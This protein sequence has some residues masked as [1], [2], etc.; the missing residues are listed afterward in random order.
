MVIRS[1]NFDF[2]KPKENHTIAL[3]LKSMDVLSN[4]EYPE[5]NNEATKEK[6]DR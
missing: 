4:S 6:K 3:V 2:V 1:L 5:R